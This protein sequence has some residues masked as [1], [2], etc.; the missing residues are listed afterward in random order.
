MEFFEFDIWSY[1][2]PDSGQYFCNNVHT[3][4]RFTPQLSSSGMLSLGQSKDELIY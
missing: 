2:G 3:D 4:T 1:V